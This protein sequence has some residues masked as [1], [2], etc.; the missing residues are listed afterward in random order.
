MTSQS[1]SAPWRRCA[2][3]ET[4]NIRGSQTE[5][6]DKTATHCSAEDFLYVS[7]NSE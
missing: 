4:E 1:Y 6:A 5:I 3:D 2:N 7:A